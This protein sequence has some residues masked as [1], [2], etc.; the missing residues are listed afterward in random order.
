MIAYS[1][2]AWRSSTPDAVTDAGPLAGAGEVDTRAASWS[3]SSCAMSIL[4]VVSC[5]T[6]RKIDCS[7]E[8]PFDAVQRVFFAFDPLRQA[9]L[10][11]GGDKAGDWNAWYVRMAPVARHRPRPRPS[12]SSRRRA[13]CVSTLHATSAW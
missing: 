10:L 7:Y 6:R 5:F 8:T 9:I 3:A 11:I 4:C 2:P 12:R 13:R 1:G